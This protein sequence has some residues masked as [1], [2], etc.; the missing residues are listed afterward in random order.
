VDAA[1]KCHIAEFIPIATVIAAFPTE[2]G[3][4]KVRT[5]AA[6]FDCLYDE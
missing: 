3:A 5:A 2:L 1:E 6:A 4:L